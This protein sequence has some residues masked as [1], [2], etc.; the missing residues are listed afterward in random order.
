M[1][2]LVFSDE[3]LLAVDLAFDVVLK[4]VSRFGEQANDFK[5][6]P[7]CVF[8]FLTPIRQKT[9][10]TDQPQ[11]CGLPSYPLRIMLDAASAGVVLAPCTGN[12]RLEIM[13]KVNGDRPRASE[14]PQ[15]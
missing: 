12:V 5:Q 1:C 7:F 2:E 4:C 8:Q 13:W 14:R 15:G 9:S 6:C 11:I 10:P 3:S